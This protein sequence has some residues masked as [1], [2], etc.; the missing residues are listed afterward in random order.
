[1]LGLGLIVTCSGAGNGCSA[2]GVVSVGVRL[3]GVAAATGASIEGVGGVGNG[4]AIGI[5]VWEA[6]GI[7][8]DDVGVDD[9]ASA[10]AVVVLQRLR[11]IVG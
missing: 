7:G 5:G 8:G 10:A 2:V 3:D 1:M 11:L 4:V 6:G 9:A